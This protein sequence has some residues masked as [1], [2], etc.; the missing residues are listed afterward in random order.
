MLNV[1]PEKCWKTVDAA[2]T[3][4][5]VNKN[6]FL[7]SRYSYDLLLLLTLFL[8]QLITSRHCVEWNLTFAFLISTVINWEKN[9]WDNCFYKFSLLIRM[10]RKFARMEMRYVTACPPA[11]MSGTSQKYRMRHFQ[12][13]VSHG[14]GPS[15][16]YW[17]AGTWVLILIAVSTSSTAFFLNKSKC[18]FRVRD[19]TWNVCIICWH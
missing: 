2:P 10:Q 5:K 9:W 15:S 8:L 16:V 4:L 13:M 11:R 3:F 14:H 1:L 12:D 6:I 7:S 19:L 18:L 17:L